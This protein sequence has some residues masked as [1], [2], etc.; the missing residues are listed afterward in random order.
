M[1]TSEDDELYFTGACTSAVTLHIF[2]FYKSMSE[3]FLPPL[4]QSSRVHP[5]IDLMPLV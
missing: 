3:Q 2:T 5:F 4:L 1:S